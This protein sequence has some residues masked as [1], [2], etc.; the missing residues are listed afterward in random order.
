MKPWVNLLNYATLRCGGNS[1]SARVD[2][3][4]RAA[5]TPRLAASSIFVATNAEIVSEKREA[6]KKNKT[7]SRDQH[8]PR[9]QFAR[10]P[11]IIYHG[12]GGAEAPASPPSLSSWLRHRSTGGRYAAQQ[13]REYGRDPRQ[14]DIPCIPIPP[15]PTGDRPPAE[16]AQDFQVPGTWRPPRFDVSHRE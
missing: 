8:M 3:R 2:E 11:P 4:A 5:R 10:A 7:S 6:K 14:R 13:R 1:K 16:A 12:D 9:E 15:P